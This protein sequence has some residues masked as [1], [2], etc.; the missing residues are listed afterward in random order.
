[1]VI[2]IPELA[3]S[4][5]FLINEVLDIIA[6]PFACIGLVTTILVVITV[7]VAWEAYEALMVLR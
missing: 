4:D 7:E 1:M 3:Q 2:V 5:N 6:E